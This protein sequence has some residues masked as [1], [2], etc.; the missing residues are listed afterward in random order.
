M[1]KLVIDQLL[2]ELSLRT[3]YFNFLSTMQVTDP[4]KTISGSLKNLNI[5]YDKKYLTVK[6]LLQHTIIQ[7]NFNSHKK[8]FINYNYYNYSKKIS[9]K[10]S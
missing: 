5:F 2:V 10:F 6:S 1:L 4:L 7:I 3:P 8:R 9:I